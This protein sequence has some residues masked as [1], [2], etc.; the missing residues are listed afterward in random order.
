MRESIQ[1]NGKLLNV[2]GNL[3]NCTWRGGALSVKLEN[4]DKELTS[5]T[6]TTT[7]SLSGGEYFTIGSSHGD[8]YY[9]WLVVDDIGNDPRVHD[10]LGVKVE[11][12]DSMDSTEVAEAIVVKLNNETT[13]DATNTANVISIATDSAA[14]LE[15]ATDYGTG[16]TINVT[17]QGVNPIIYDGIPFNDIRQILD[18]SIA[19]D[20]SAQFT[21]EVEKDIK[22]PKIPV[23]WSTKRIDYVKEYR[24]VGAGFFVLP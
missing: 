7:G 4:A 22:L 14:D 18:L 21:V 10:H 11:L 19:V 13:L 20:G 3:L 12:E 1:L 23:A 15:D 16:F 9:V 2:D 17:Q 5:I 8:K 6:C 24:A